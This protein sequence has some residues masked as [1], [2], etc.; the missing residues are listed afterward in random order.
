MYITLSERMKSFQ[1]SI[2][3][4]LS[5]YKKQKLAQGVQMIDL[6][7]GS[8]DLA[9]PGFITKTL[10][11]EVVKNDQYGYSLTGTSKFNQAVST[12]YMR[13]YQVELQ[14]EQEVLMMMGSQDG[15]VH[16]PMVFANPGDI[17][18]VPDPGYTAYAT[19]I[20]M[21]GAR[22]YLMPLKKNNKYLPDLSI[23]PDEIAEKAKLMILNF[24]GNPVPALASKEYFTEVVEF[25]KKHNILVLHDF[26]YSEIYFDDNKPVSFLSID[27]AKDIGVEMS[28]FSKNYNM[29]GS[30]IGYLAGNEQIVQAMNQLKSNL[31][32]GVFLPI[33][34][35]AIQALEEGAEYCQESRKVY[36]ARRDLLVNGLR[37]IGWDIMKPDAGMFIWAE[38]PKGW[39]SLDFTYA[40]IDKANVVVIPGDAFGPSGEGFVRIALVQGEDKLKEA[41]SLIDQAKIIR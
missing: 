33:Q 41:I 21:A 32:Y 19:G 14:S 23:I 26:A 3:S 38:I 35:A 20:T 28:S 37:E 8:P 16:F 10:S 24:P 36:Q 11:Q 1:P 7:I 15:L 6:S 4:E 27:G 9:P 25:A 13:N 39:K 17:I 40:L 22:P 5:N 12:F 29:A 31:D 18:L 30:R 2:F 34:T